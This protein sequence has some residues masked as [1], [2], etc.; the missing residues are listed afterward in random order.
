MDVYNSKKKSAYQRQYCAF[1]IALCD[2]PEFQNT[3]FSQGYFL[4]V[5]FG[6]GLTKY[7]NFTEVAGG[8]LK[9]GQ[10]IVTDF[11]SGG[12]ASLN[13]NSN[14]SMRGMMRALR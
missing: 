10:K 14:D 2:L 11:A 1:N 4:P 12:K 5:C 9:E 13:S 3:D 6:L 7:S 8:G